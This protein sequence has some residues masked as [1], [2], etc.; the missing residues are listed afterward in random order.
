MVDVHISDEADELAVALVQ[1]LARQDGEQALKLAEALEP[2]IG[3][4]PS[5]RAR[6]ATWMAQAYQIVGKLPEAAAMIRQAITLAQAAGDTDAI[7]ALKQLKA[8]IVRGKVAA[9]VAANM[10]LPETLLGRAVKAIDDNDY[11]T[12]ASLARQARIEAQSMGNFRDEVFALLALARIPGQE[13]SAIRA[14]YDV[15]DSVDDKNLVTA[16]SRAAKA[17]DVPL[18]KKIF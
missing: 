5:L 16:V 2:V 8:E 15:A 12:G 4:R 9:D 13:D 11:E 17:A 10:P 14:A 7:P 1:A 3:N 6:H 18:P